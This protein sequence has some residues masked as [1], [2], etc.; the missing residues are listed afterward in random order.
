[1]IQALVEIAGSLLIGGIGLA[2]ILICSILFMILG[3]EVLGWLR[4]RRLP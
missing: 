2:L 1:M 3:K 4:D